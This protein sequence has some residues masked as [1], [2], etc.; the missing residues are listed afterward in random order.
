MNA[1]K[2][3]LYAGSVMHVRLRPRRHRLKYRLFQLLLDLDDI[4]ALDNRLR[5]FSRNR[6]NLF[7]FHDGDHGDRTGGDLRLHIDR[8]LAAHSIEPCDGRILLLTMPRILGYVFNPLSVY[9]CYRKTG[10]LHAIVYEVSNTFGGK[11]D[12]VFAIEPQDGDDWLQHACD[13]QFLVSP[14]LEMDLTYAF[15][16][17]PPRED[18]ALSIMVSDRQGPL[19]STVQTA[20]R[21]ALSDATLARAALAYPLMTLK[22]IAGIHWEAASPLAEGRAPVAVPASARCRPRAPQATPA[23]R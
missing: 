22:V 10:A 5:L 13:K 2:S 20:R 12:Y 21:R 14:F 18:L 11:H 7:S 4:D 16:V 23:S 9:F 1:Q 15:R 8:S 19:L 3:H 17:R 6:F